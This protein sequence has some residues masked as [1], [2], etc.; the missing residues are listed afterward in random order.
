M[1]LDIEGLLQKIK[2]DL[3]IILIRMHFVFCDDA[4]TVLGTIDAKGT[5]YNTT[6]G[7]WYFNFITQKLKFT[8]SGSFIG[9]ATV[10]YNIKAGLNNEMPY[11]DEAYRSTPSTVRVDIIP[12]KDLI[13]NWMVTSVIV[14]K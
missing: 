8:P 6:N 12:S 5:T 9:Q 4:G 13:Y 1:I 7:A 14:P 11:N 3:K 10:K 2:L